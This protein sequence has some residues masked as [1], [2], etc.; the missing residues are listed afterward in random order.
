MIRRTFEPH[1]SQL[2]EPKL[3]FRYGQ[4]LEYPRDGLFLYGPVD[5]VHAPKQINYGVIGTKS[6]VNFFERWVTSIQSFINVP[7]P[8]KGS[9][10][11]QP[12]NVAF[13]GF[14]E[15]FSADWP[16]RPVCVVDGI[17]SAELDRTLRLESRHE[18]VHKTVMLYVSRLIHEHNRLDN[19]PALWFVIIPDSVYHF[20]RPQSKVALSERVKGDITITSRQAQRLRIQPTLFGEEN[21]Q[22]EVFD[23]ALDFHNQLKALLLKEKIVTQILRETTLAPNE[24]LKRNNLPMRSV[25]DP[26]KIAWNVC[27]TAYY[28]AGGRPWQLADVRPGVCYVGLVYKRERSADNRW[29]CCAAQMFLTDGDGIVF[30]GALGPW[31]NTERGDFHLDRSAAGEIVHMV[32]EEYRE[33]FAAAPK[34]LFIHSRSRFSRDEWDGFLEV[35]PRE[36][37][38]VGVQITK[39]K[40]MK[41]FRPGRYPV[42]RGT[43][44]HVDAA[45]SFLWTTG[46]VPRLDTYMGS[47]TPNPIRISVV[48]G[49]CPVR[50]VLEDVLRLTKINFNAC[51]F[52]SGMPMTIK[53]ADAVGNVLGA[54]PSSEPRL[55]FMFYI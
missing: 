17:D 4:K 28:K 25:G 38:L 8:A 15:A 33:K 39:P 42:I 14:A 27:T 51:S 46:Y 40:D 48:R 19:P 29:A 41:L 10:A 5:Y 35:T 37:N 7:E 55:P 50:T 9:R 49:A 23:Y 34:E 26:A 21:E 16:R 1:V 18:A 32:I 52:S 44:L 11:L 24:F 53:F 54:A 2:E 22:L 36:T 30:R 47:E 45:T 43:A 20:C 31:Y 6:G 3:E 12:Q 13:P